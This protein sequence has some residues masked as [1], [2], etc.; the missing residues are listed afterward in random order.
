[1][2]IGFKETNMA[3]ILNEEGVLQLTSRDGRG[4]SW[5]LGS[6]Y[7]MLKVSLVVVVLSLVRLTVNFM[8]LMQ[9]QMLEGLQCN[10]AVL[11]VKFHS[12]LGNKD[13]LETYIQLIFHSDFMTHSSC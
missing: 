4:E 13:S 2:Y 1:M 12:F 10:K 9:V 7:H 8:G 11:T 6:Y 3:D 5:S